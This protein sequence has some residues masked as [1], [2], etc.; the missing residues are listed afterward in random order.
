VDN[1][2]TRLSELL[3]GESRFILLPKS[4]D[5]TYEVSYGNTENSEPVCK[6]YVEGA[7]YHAE[8]I[9]AGPNGPV[10]KVTLPL[11]SELLIL[12]MV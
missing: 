12:K 10:C 4:G 9:L 8:T 1:K 5:G 2:E 7:M 6:D 3:P 11:F